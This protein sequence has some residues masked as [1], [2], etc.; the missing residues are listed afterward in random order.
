MD[1]DADIDLC[2]KSL[3]T[4]WLVQLL[5]VAW[6]S[7]TLYDYLF[8]LT[9][10]IDLVWTD[11]VSMTSGIYFILR[12]LGMVMQLIYVIVGLQRLPNLTQQILLLTDEGVG[13]RCLSV[14]DSDVRA[15]KVVNESLLELIVGTIFLIQPLV[16]A[17]I[18]WVGSIYLAAL[19]II[20]LL[21]VYALYKASKRLLLVLGACFILEMACVIFALQWGIYS[22][23]A[24]NYGLLVGAVPWASFELLLLVLILRASYKHRQATWGTMRIGLNP[25][26][27]I[28]VRDSSIYFLGFI[29]SSAL[30]IICALYVE[31]SYL[32]VASGAALANLLGP[33]LVLTLRK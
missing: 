6:W 5:S 1:S 27:K 12:Y 8:Q 32:G 33:R 14:I 28:V 4:M 9:N 13:S 15:L 22:D 17:T 26:L 20:L 23:R 25:L 31:E 21:R 30:L 10:E 3:S 19:Q 29:C 18:A 11:P 2:Y 7:V 24:N 16:D